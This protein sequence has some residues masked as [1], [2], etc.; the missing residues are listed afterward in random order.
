MLCK[1]GL[2]RYKPASCSC[3]KSLGGGTRELTVVTA[4]VDLR[5]PV[6]TC[7]RGQ[8]GHVQSAVQQPWLCSASGRPRHQIMPR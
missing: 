4:K 2:P 3:D 6:Q 5:S 8:V 7:R 1:A